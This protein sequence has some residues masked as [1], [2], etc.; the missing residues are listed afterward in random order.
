MVSDYWYISVDPYRCVGTGICA[1]AAP[2]HFALVNDVSTPLAE[3]VAPDQAVCDAA[4]CCPMEAITVRDR[5]GRIIAP[6]P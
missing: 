4:E 1:S 2:Q 5:D 3:R 6:E